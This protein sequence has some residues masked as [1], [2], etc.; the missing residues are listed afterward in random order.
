MNNTLC[1]AAWYDLNIDFGKQKL[2]HCCKQTFEEFPDKLENSFFDQSQHIQNVRND[3]I[4]GVENSTCDHCWSSYKKTGTAYRD[5][6]NKWKTKDDID[7][8]VDSIEISLDNLCDM[9]CVYCD[10][11]FS[12]RIASEF[13][14][15]AQVQTPNKEHMDKFIKY[16]ETDP[17]IR[18]GFSLS[19]L[20]GEVTYSKNFFYFVDRMLES[21]LINKRINFGFLTN[22]NTTE[23]IM[24]KV[25]ILLDKIP[26]NWNL[27]IGVS[28]EA[29]GEVAEN[30]RHGLDFNRFDKNFR[31]YA[32]HARVECITI[33]P[34]PSIFTVKE[35][36]AFFEYCI[37]VI[38]NAQQK[39]RIA[40]FGNWV[41]WPEILDPKH[42]DKEYIQYVNQAID[43]VENARSV[44]DDNNQI[45]HTLRWLEMLKQR[46]GT[47]SL[48]REEIDKFITHKVEIKNNKNLEKLRTY[49]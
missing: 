8:R 28:N 19:F 40:I 25:K 3:L 23:K 21:T 24:N 22:A 43:I 35:L 42:L 49:I 39:T 2:R 17:S 32:N 37:D 47:G 20:G 44:F 45:S 14:L 10:V 11:M 27:S 16:L 13:G 18:D 7:P 30:V 12:S 5:F 1:S 41:E 48:D 34:T 31:Y 36:P 38:K 4:N 15:K 29:M 26:N 46:I 9:S 33:S 6:K